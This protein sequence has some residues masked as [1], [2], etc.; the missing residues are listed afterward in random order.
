MLNVVKH[1]HIGEHN[2]STFHLQHR[3]Q[4]WKFSIKMTIFEV[5]SKLLLVISINEIDCLLLM[6]SHFRG[7]GNAWMVIKERLSSIL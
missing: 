6:E 7:R 3:E 2:H 5:L 1:S 4:L